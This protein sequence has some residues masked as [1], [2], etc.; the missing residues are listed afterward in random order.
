MTERYL[1]EIL[2]KQSGCSRRILVRDRPIFKE[3]WIK[4]DLLID[5]LLYRVTIMV[6]KNEYN[7][8]LAATVAWWKLKTLMR[9]S[10]AVHY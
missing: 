5:C 4:I 6:N 8:I 1:H 9:L 7:I 3:N 2:V 10:E